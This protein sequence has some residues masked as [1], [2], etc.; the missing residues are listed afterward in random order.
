M[1]LSIDCGSTNL[2]AALYDAALNRIGVHSVPVDY[3]RRDSVHAEFD[4]DLL[5]T[6]FMKMAGELFARTGCSPASLR[7]IAF[8]SQAQSFC[9]LDADDHPLLPFISWM[10]VRAEVESDL[11]ASEFGR[12]FHRHSSF[13]S[14]M[15]ALEISKLLWVRAHRP[16]V[17]GR[18]R[19]LVSVP[20]FLCLRLAGVNLMDTNLAAMNGF[21]SM[22]SDGWWKEILAY[23]GVPADWLP[24]LVPSGQAR[25]ACLQ[26]PGWPGAGVDL[27]LAGNDHT[28]G[29]VG[30]GCRAGDI[31]VTFGTALVAYRRTGETPGPYHT[32]GCWGPYPLG[33]YYE[34][35]ASSHGCSALDWARGI[36][37]HEEPAAAFDAL[38][39]TAGLGSGDVRFYPERSRTE[40]AWAGNGTPAERA[41]AVLEGLLFSLRRMLA[42]D[43]Q[44]WPPSRVCALG[45]GGKSPF[46]MQMAA[47]ILGCPVRMGQGDG[48]LG[49]AALAAGRAQD[50]EARAG[51]DW[52]PDP[53]RRGRYD[54]VFGKWVLHLPAGQ[55]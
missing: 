23:G 52:L 20:G 15:A 38:A 39:A 49:A 8:G 4:A 50:L 51:T 14:P 43:M 32:G 18:A 2:K 37:L 34:L 31:I 53:D 6:A 24:E 36:L 41:R 40:G 33:G 47:D 3:S 26:V 16:D 48:L 29:A 13:S 21:Y 55:L 30:N 35:A 19:R 10:D 45:G 28:A 17:W 12:D 54:S 1:I 7:Q 25:R 9:L 42:D 27:V 22:V 44:A 46:W 5:W 11:L